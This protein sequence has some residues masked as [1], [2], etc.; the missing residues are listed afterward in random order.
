MSANLQWVEEKAS[1]WDDD[2]QRI[3]GGAPS[4]VFDVRFSRC[5]AGDLLPGDWWRVERDGATVGY[6]WLDVV[7][8]DAEILLAVA[9][10]ARGEGVGSFIMDKLEAEARSRGLNYCYNSVRPTHPD[11]EAVTAWLEKRGFT[12]N[13]DG[14]LFRSLT[15]AASTS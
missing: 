8:G 3:I 2:K 13:E 4:G 11:R 14:S 9:D 1:K 6:G 15:H 10:A 12:A 7:W 5:G